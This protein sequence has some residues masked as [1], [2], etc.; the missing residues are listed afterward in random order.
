MLLALDNAAA[1]LPTNTLGPCRPLGAPLQQLD[2]QR[3]RD[4]LVDCY[5]TGTSASF[6][7]CRSD[8][9]LVAA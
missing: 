4:T 5:E 2:P 7:S 1:D 3:K 8:C 9:A 6:S